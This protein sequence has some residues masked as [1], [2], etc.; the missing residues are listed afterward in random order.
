MKDH[1][2][3]SKA[4]YRGREGNAPL[5]AAT[6]LPKCNGLQKSTIDCNTINIATPKQPKLNK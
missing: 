3:L 1:N 2:L 6:A 5:N 4:R